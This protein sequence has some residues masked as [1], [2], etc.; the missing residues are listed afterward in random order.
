MSRLAKLATDCAHQRRIE[1]STY[2]VDETHILSRGRLIEE[3][4]K[5]YY[6]LTGERVE[7]GPLHNLEILMLVRTPDLVIEDIEVITGTLPRADCYRIV[8][9][10]DPVKGL[11]IRSGFTSKVRELAGGV[12][13]CTHLTHLLCTM[14]P[15]VMQG[16]WA[17][18]YQKKYE[19]SGRSSN[20]AAKMGN[21][22]KDSCFAWREEGEAYQ[23]IVRLLREDAE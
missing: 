15:A 19:K 2:P 14:A 20:R 12:K 10:L 3:R 17:I 8:H 22:L 16:Y 13:G 23:R 7:S 6:K 4:I 11:A 5:P 9:S 21:M 1:M 18:S